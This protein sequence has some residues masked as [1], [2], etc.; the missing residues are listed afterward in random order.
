MLWVETDVLRLAIRAEPEFL[1]PH[2]HDLVFEPTR[3]PRV[4]LL[5]PHF[6]VL[7]VDAAV[8]L[9]QIQGF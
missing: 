2:A 8:G 5:E 6:E 1:P 3:K 4:R 7:Q 9:D